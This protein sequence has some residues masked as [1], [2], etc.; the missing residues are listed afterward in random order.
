MSND[1][2]R[3]LHA[4]AL[5]PGSDAFGVIAMAAYRPNLELFRRQIES[6]RLQT[7]ENFLCL[8]SADGDSETL[9]RV[10]SAIVGSDPRFKLL[11]FDERLG[12]YGNF[13]RVL[14]NVP[15]VAEW[16]ALSDQDDYWYPNKI[17]RLVSQLAAYPLVASQSRVVEHPTGLVL[18]ERTRRICVKPQSYFVE[19]QYT[20]G[21]M[22]FRRDVLEV[23]LPFPRFD[24]P[25]EVHDHWIAV[26]ASAKGQCRVIDDVLQDY[27]QH[28]ENVLGEAK[29]GFSPLRSYRNLIAL[30]QKGR[31]S[32]SVGD[33]VQTMYDVGAGWREVMADELRERTHDLDGDIAVAVRIFG[34]GRPRWR[35]YWSVLGGWRSGE[36]TVRAALEYVIGD[37]AVSLGRLIMRRAWTRDRQ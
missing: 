11:G 34:S 3:D 4:E 8:V 36:I 7:H 16:V 30:S 25:S 14:K 19:N 2:D 22:A 12:F 1:Q 37:A 29:A 6:I 10:L 17:E 26:C 13:E 20:G 15:S 27:V 28:G 35:T 24:S 21:T 18:A 31:G 23:A 33:V 32:K 9:E 5:I